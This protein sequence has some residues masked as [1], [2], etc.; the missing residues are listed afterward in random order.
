MLEAGFLC[1][2]DG[3]YHLI[4]PWQR[5]VLGVCTRV[6]QAELH[7]VSL[8]LS[9]ASVTFLIFLIQTLLENTPFSCLYQTHQLP[10]LVR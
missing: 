3:L 5:S 6:E 7:A 1:M 4:L 9:P 8:V 10:P 2:P